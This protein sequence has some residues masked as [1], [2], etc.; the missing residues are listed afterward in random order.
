M[1]N[2]SFQP[3]INR[4]ESISIFKRKRVATTQSRDGTVRTINSGGQT[5][6]FT[7]SLPG[8]QVWSQDRGLIESIEAVD[9]TGVFRIRL[10]NP[11][12]SWMIDYQGDL[13]TVGNIQVAIGTTDTLTIT[14]GATGLTTGQ[15]KFRKGDVIQT[16]GGTNP[17]YTVI[18]D[19]PH[20]S[21]T[22]R[23]HRP[24]R[25]S[26]TAL[27]SV[28]SN[29]FWDVV[30]VEFPDWTWVNNN[31]YSWSGSFVFAEALI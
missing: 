2:T 6:E 10:N 26:G 21:N 8:S 31:L 25:D 3:L 20:D 17:V 1:S 18:E 7:V 19:V 13:P 23:V 9:R 24:V 15:F 14:S 11:G 4:A 28:G 29:V 5:W 22:I 12:H 16:L 27:L 30:C